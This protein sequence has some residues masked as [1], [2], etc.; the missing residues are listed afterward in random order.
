MS[1]TDGKRSGTQVALP[2]PVER[3]LRNLGQDISAA[4]RMRRLSQGELAQRIGAS[5]STVRRMEDGYPGTAL[6]TFLRTLQV[7]GRL[8]ALV[9]VMSLENDELGMELVREQLPQRV[10]ARGSKSRPGRSADAKSSGKVTPHP[11]E[12]EGF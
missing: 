11:D 8:E 3:A 1:A 7:L 10:R 4:R 9:K 6:H 12:L 5:L 2:R